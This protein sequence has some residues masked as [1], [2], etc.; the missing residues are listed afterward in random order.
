MLVNLTLMMRA[1]TVR[2]R[3][4]GAVVIVALALLCVAAVGIAGQFYSRAVSSSFVKQE[5]A[6]MTHI[7][8]LRTTM[9]AL[10]GIEKDMIIQYGKKERVAA[11]NKSWACLLYTSPSPRD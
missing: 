4:L 10:R 8:R 9:S 11:L 2:T 1:F 6:A 3:M 7:A 5:F